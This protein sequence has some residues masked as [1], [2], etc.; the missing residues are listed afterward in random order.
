MPTSLVISSAP[1]AAASV[2]SPAGFTVAHAR[3]LTAAELE[4]LLS[5]LQQPTALIEL[6]VLCACLALAW[7]FMR[8][9]RGKAANASSIWFG[10]HVVDGILFPL[11]ALLLAL[12]A[13]RVLQDS[14]PLAV[15]RLAI[16]VLSSLA[17][18]RLTV[19]VL[20]A[21][22][23]ASSALGIV[24]RT[25][26]WGAWLVT[27]LWIT[28]VL[29][30]VLAE[31]DQVTW[32]IGSSEIS[33]RNLIEGT[34]SAVLVMIL[35]LSLSS[36]LEAR[37]LQGATDNLSLRK[38]AANILRALLLVVGLMLAM[39]AVGVDLTAL[40]VFGGAL[41]VGVGM[42]LQKLAA[43]YVSGFVILAERS[44][45]IGD[46]VKVDNFEGVI[47]DINTRFTVIRAANGRESIV[48]NEVLI[49]QRVENASLADSRIAMMTTVQVAYGTDLELLM[50]RLQA[51]VKAVPRVVDDPAPA[52][53]LTQF[54]ADGLELTVSFWIMDPESGQ[55]GARSE[56]NL[57]LLA[58]INKLGVVIPFP[59][60][61]MH[62]AASQSSLAVVGVVSSQAP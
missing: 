55:L 59:Q 22:F 35:S 44:L 30:I 29:P 3:P 26:S 6:G 51:A 17:V 58:E 56:V 1:P 40:S 7:L 14:I 34:L 62:Q 53:L 12:I 8:F 10:R 13:R 45:R 37:L 23:P 5:R 52:V 38:M 57:A 32:K 60:R 2:P 27:A 31:L 61:V 41:G 24:E 33:L 11:L 43:N 20:G 21:A 9:L 49:T 19:K 36:A 18:I 28:G 25:V 50:P 46:L 42:G 47:T 48:P 54:A 16:P 39:S 4:L 15:F